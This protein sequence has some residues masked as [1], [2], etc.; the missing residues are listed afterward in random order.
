MTPTQAA[1]ILAAHNA[2]RRRDD[3][4]T[5]QAST[6]MQEPLEVGQAIDLAVAALRAAAKESKA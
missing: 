4:R 6:P 2:W 1:E 5:D 3:D